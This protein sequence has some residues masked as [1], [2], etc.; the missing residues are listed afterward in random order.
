MVVHGPSHQARKLATDPGRLSARRDPPTPGRRVDAQGALAPAR[1]PPALRR[2]PPPARGRLGEGPDDP[3]A[4]ARGARARDARGATD[5]A[6]VG[7]VLADGAR[8]RDPTG[9]LL[10]RGGREEAAEEARARAREDEGRAAR[11]TEPG[12]SI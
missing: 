9:A 4:R 12:A 6:P 5:V 2:A 10:D 8:R 11:L 3:T 1:R 7:R